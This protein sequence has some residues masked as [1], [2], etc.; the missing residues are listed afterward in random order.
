[1]ETRRSQITNPLSNLKSYVSSH[2][3]LGW[4][5]VGPVEE[6]ILRED[7]DHKYCA[8]SKRENYIATSYWTLRSPDTNP[9][10]II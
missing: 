5:F 3:C 4:P 6:R 2:R 9:N 7:N 10:D 8:E 1:M